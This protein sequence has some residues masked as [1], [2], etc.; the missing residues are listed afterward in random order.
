VGASSQ[1]RKVS[2]GLLLLTSLL[3]INLQSQSAFGA[4]TTPKADKTCGKE[5]TTFKL[6]KITLVCTKI[7]SKLSWQ[8]SVAQIQLNIWKDLKSKRSLLPNVDTSFEIHLSP[9][10]SVA[11]ANQILESFN[12][13]AKLWQVQYLPS[14]PLPSIFFTEKDRDWVIEKFNDLGFYSENFIANFDDEVN[15]NSDRSNWA[16]ITGENGNLWMSYMVGTRKETDSND[17]QVAAH[18]YTHL[19]QFSIA[20]NQVTDLSCWQVEGGANF[21]GLYL[22]ATN[23]K[24]LQDFVKERNT[25]PFF[26]G[27]AGLNKQPS[28]NWGKL[29]D[30]FGPNFDSTK[31]GPDGAYPVGS[32][33]HEYLYTLKGHAGIVQML[34]DV[35]TEKDFY[36]GIEKTYGKKWTTVKS[37]FVKYLKT[38]VAQLS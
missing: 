31:C 20:N 5:K 17:L 19:V 30:S 6:G 12:Q 18:E 4:D 24:Q 23:E 34:K 3:T 10:V 38:V 25:Q 33:M 28:K 8:P 22:G 21:Y 29:I 7:D 9:T 27:F 15:R 13:A 36:K 11:S 1:V 16:G 2:V 14:R 35:S 32:V 37:E 26:L